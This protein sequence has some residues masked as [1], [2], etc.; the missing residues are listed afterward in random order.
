MRTTTVA[1]GIRSNSMKSPSKRRRAVLIACVLGGTFVTVGVAL[2]RTRSSEPERANPAIAAPL[3][4]PSVSPEVR[5]PAAIELG[6]QSAADVPPS[7]PSGPARHVK[8]SFDQQP[9]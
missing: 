3:T 6:A 1:P 9:S 2:L 7:T 8:E 5:A 4:V